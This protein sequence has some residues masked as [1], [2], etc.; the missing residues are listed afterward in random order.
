MKLFE[1]ANTGNQYTLYR[2]DSVPN[3]TNFRRTA[4]GALGAGIYLTG[5][6]AAAKACGPHVT[7]VV[8]TINNPIIVRDATESEM[9]GAIALDDQFWR[10]GFNSRGAANKWARE[11]WEDFSGIEDP[12]FV[13]VMRHANKDGVI[14][15][16]G[17]KIVEATVLNMSQIRIIE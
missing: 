5:D 4:G 7:K 6:P 2:G 1:I 11:Q 8:A 9:I 10:A 13:D 3:L 12:E 16:Q 17:N 15:Y 14:L